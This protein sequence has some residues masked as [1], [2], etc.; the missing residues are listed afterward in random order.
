MGMSLSGAKTEMAPI[1]KVML[2]TPKGHPL[3]PSALCGAAIILVKPMHAA[4][5]KGGFRLMSLALWG[6]G[7]SQLD[8]NY[9]LYVTN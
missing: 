5:Q 8:G 3:A 2:R 1:L 7:F 9:G 4:L 6:F